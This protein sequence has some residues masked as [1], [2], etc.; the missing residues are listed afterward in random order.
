M[1]GIFGMIAGKVQQF[2]L[3]IVVL[4]LFVVR[5]CGAGAHR[6]KKMTKKRKLNCSFALSARV[7][8]CNYVMPSK[9]KTF[10]CC[11]HNPYLIYRTSSTRGRCCPRESAAVRVV[12]TG[13][14]PLFP[15]GVR[16]IFQRGHEYTIRL[17]TIKNTHL[18]THPPLG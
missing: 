14:R 2:F 12:T 17:Y 18:I 8:L 16:L 11:V 4:L 15:P 10:F 6:T 1:M 5:P 9:A 3:L 7:K 13:C